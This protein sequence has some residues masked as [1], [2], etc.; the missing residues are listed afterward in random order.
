MEEHCDRVA[1]THRNTI[2]VRFR[3]QDEKVKKRKVLFLNLPH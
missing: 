2:C 1:V 3:Q